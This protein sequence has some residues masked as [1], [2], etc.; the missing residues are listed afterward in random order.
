MV[1]VTGGT[2]MVGVRLIFDLLTNNNKI[3]AL[4]RPGTSI[5]K[6]KSQLGFYTTLTEALMERIQW[7]EGDVLDL[8][9]LLKHIPENAEVYHCAAFVSFRKA[10]R[11][12]IFETNVEGTANVV[13]ACL[14]KK[15]KKLCHVSSI[16]A[17]G[18]KIKGQLVDETTPWSASGKSGYSLSKYYSEME[19]WRGIAEGLSAVIVNP[20]VILG[21]GIWNEGSPSFFPLIDKGLKFFTK[22]ST[23]YV[24]VRD[25]SRAMIFLMNNETEGSRFIQAAETLSYQQFFSLIADKLNVD[26]PK[27]YANRLITGIAWR[28]L[29]L[30]SLF[31]RSTPQI[32]RQTHRVSHAT[33]SYSGALF[34]QKSGFEY[35]PINQTVDYIAKLYRQS[36]PERKT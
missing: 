5:Q 8:E 19:I 35:T 16:A 11:K 14:Q 1:F 21:P 13:N 23:S 20:A 27:F 2:G 30:A 25:V 9:S 18:G 12:K 32:T 34:A 3:V 31:T 33:D 36:K 7:V 17:I 26:R 29:A 22:G 24:D 28:L 6:F 15:V 4:I 10:D